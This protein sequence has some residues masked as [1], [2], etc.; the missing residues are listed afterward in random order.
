MPFEA[1]GAEQKF[2]M[3]VVMNNT[4]RQH[5]LPRFLLKGFASRTEQEKSSKAQYY[6]FHFR[7]DTKPHEAN[8]VNIAVI[9]NFY[10]VDGPDSVEG[11]LS[12]AENEHA[13]LIRD[14]LDSKSTIGKED[15]IAE[16]IG[17]LLMRS[18]HMRTQSI[19][20]AEITRD[21]M[22]R[23]WS[24]EENNEALCQIVWQTMDN[25]MPSFISSLP[26]REQYAMKASIKE[27]VFE[28]NMTQFYKHSVIPMM[29]LMDMNEIVKNSHVDALSHNI[30]SVACENFLERFYWQIIEAPLN[31]LI[32]GDVGPV[33]KIRNDTEWHVLYDKPKET[34]I[35]CMPVSHNLLLVG[36]CESFDFPFSFDEVNKAMAEL[37]MQFFI[38]SR[39]TEKE[40]QLFA[41][42]G[43]RARVF[44]ADDINNQIKDSLNKPLD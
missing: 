7:T 5:H 28:M 34:E 14:L 11:K 19:L 20:A 44:S 35:I 39:H 25:H 18:Y 15:Q 1:G 2:I 21:S 24:D 10:G 43:K 41:R 29:D 37:S 16:F 9:K 26:I 4:K 27:F 32:L 13:H 33:V 3:E 36:N 17:C 23:E 40:Q 42:L 12:V 38:A 8:T 22:K 31:T 30:I 6:A